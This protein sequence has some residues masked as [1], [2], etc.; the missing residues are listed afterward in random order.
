MKLRHIL[1]ELIS[2]LP[3]AVQHAPGLQRDQDFN[4]PEAG[5][6][7]R[8]FGIGSDGR[9][10]T[11]SA[12]DQRRLRPILLRDERALR[13]EAIARERAKRRGDTPLPVNFAQDAPKIDGNQG[14][15]TEAAF[16]GVPGRNSP[17]DAQKRS[18]RVCGLWR[19]TWQFCEVTQ[20]WR[21]RAWVMGAPLGAPDTTLGLIAA[22]CPAPPR[23]AKPCRDRQT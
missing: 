20:T 17:N 23:R 15:S 10:Y 16:P 2:P 19:W 8:L 12:A 4:P 5:V 9:V 18:Q 7:E 3:P 21:Y 13:N 6:L 14:A 1:K 11:V 22:P